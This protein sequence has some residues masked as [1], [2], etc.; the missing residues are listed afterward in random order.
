MIVEQCDNL[1][2]LP[3]KCPSPVIPCSLVLDPSL[4]QLS[5]L[6]PV[7]FL[8]LL[9]ESA[10]INWICILTF[11]QLFEKIFPRFSETI[12]DIFNNF[13]FI[14]HFLQSGIWCKKRGR[15]FCFMLSKKSQFC[16]TR[17][18]QKLSKIRNNLGI[19]KL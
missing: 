18:P 1:S 12:W 10:L 16:S 7:R 14:F 13:V 17:I 11:H 4:D 6:S 8:E 9:T 2:F 19:L 5:S 15:I 3:I